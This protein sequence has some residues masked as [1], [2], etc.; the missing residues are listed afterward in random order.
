MPTGPGVQPDFSDAHFQLGSYLLDREVFAD[1]EASFRR[2][3]E[4][5]PDGWKI[6]VGL[7]YA[8]IEMGRFTEAE[9]ASR[10]AIEFNPRDNIS[11]NN[12][13]VALRGQER[14]PE[15][16][17][18]F[19]RAIELDPND[20]KSQ[21]NLGG[22]LSKVRTDSRRQKQPFVGPLNLNPTTT[23]P[24]SISATFSKELADPLRQKSH[25][26]GRSN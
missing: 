6:H 20:F 9:A 22:A 4:T 25:T 8:L 26:A 21:N 7:A 24:S 19:R 5:E 2:P 14:Y 18:A 13:G 10:R 17:A 3:I 16:E 15:A 12:L 23:L 11:Y 1:A